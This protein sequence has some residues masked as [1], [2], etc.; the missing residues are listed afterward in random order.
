MSWKA[1]IRKCCCCAQLDIHID[2]DDIN[3]NYRIGADEKKGG[4]LMSVWTLFF[5]GSII[6]ECDCFKM[7]SFKEKKSKERIDSPPL[8]VSSN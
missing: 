4:T 3:R 8:F 7:R 2:D 5:F 1:A 6:D